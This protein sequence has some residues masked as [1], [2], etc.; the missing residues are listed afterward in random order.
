MIVG[1]EVVR[2][3]ELVG[4]VGEVPEGGDRVV[5]ES[6]GRDRR[7]RGGVVFVGED[8]EVFVRPEKVGEGAGEG[9]PEVE[10]LELGEREE[11]WCLGAG[12]GV[13]AVFL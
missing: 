13:S 3:L 2:P 5:V 6:R 4:R 10:V 9:G 12:R 1:E 11:G 7:V 8:D